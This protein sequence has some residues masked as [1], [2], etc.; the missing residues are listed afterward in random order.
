MTIEPVYK[1][2]IAP[3]QAAF[4]MLNQ[5]HP[6]S[7]AYNIPLCV[8]LEGELDRE[9]LQDALNFLVQRHEILRTT[10]DI[11]DE[12]IVQKVQPAGE[13]VL[14]VEHVDANNDS[15]SLDDWILQNRQKH[16]D[17]MEGPLLY[18]DLRVLS[19]YQHILLIVMHH[20]TVDHTAVGVLIEE[21]GSAYRTLSQKIAVDLPEQSL[22]YADYVVWRR[23][24]SNEELLATKL[25]YWKNRL[26]GFSGLINL[27]LDRPRPPTS[28]S[29]GA[30]YLFDLTAEQSEL[31]RRFS[32]ERA[33]SLY[34]TLLSV[35][36]LMWRYLC[37][38]D[39]IIVGA[40]FANRG[41]QEELDR[42]L[43]CF[44]NTLPLAT[45]FENILNFD[46]LLKSVKEVMLEA[47]DNQE[48][49]FERIVD[50]V[51]KERDHSYNPLYQV[52]FLF[53]EP[54]VEIKLSG[55]KCTAIDVHS[56][57][58]MRDFSIWIWEKES[59]LSGLVWYNTDVFDESTV[60]DLVNE[61]TKVIDW[62]LQQPETG[63]DLME[64]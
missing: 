1:F 10:Y 12:G 41:D 42:V 35:Y 45:N 11:D 56:G 3:I 53:Q 54:P 8:R 5:I 29:Q 64:F 21:L 30:Q 9:A 55:L 7:L 46:S 57:G 60:I 40:A 24:N 34:Q 36:K 28:T 52:G 38:Q 23:E 48:V 17:L 37:K 63:F 20:I 19:E 4:F 39:D 26:A 58:S 47:Y 32:S 31:V 61:Y 18:A 43:G 16:F 15:M 13:C 6:E 59:Y 62:A 25:D 50:A 51:C 2:P 33:V 22:Q 49:S 44:L 14:S 27:P